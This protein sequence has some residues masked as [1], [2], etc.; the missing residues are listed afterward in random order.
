VRALTRMCKSTQVGTGESFQIRL[1]VFVAEVLELVL[2]SCKIEVENKL[3]G[4]QG[5]SDA[6]VLGLGTSKM[7]VSIGRLSL[8]ACF[9]ASGF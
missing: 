6:G 1:W 3:S 7:G 2:A 4:L 9:K 8:F 5:C